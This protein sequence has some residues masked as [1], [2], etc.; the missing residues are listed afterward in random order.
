MSRIKREFF[1]SI[2]VHVKKIRLLFE[3]FAVIHMS[4]MLN[5]NLFSFL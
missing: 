1:L 3:K 2:G 4:E 5:L